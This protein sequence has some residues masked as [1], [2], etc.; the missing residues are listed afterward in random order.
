MDQTPQDRLGW[1]QIPE[2]MTLEQIAGVPPAERRQLS[3][4]VPEVLD[5]H[6]RSAL[7]REDH[8]LQASR[9]NVVALALDRFLREEGY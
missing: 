9:Q 5:L 7:Y 4:H 1:H 8:G 2:E 3:V 6:R